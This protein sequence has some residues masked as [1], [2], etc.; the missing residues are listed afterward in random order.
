MSGLYDPRF[1]HDACGLA[2]VVRLDGNRT[3]EVVAAGIEALRNLDHRGA[4]GSDPETGD[5]AGILLQLP[6]TF[7]R[8][9][10]AS[11]GIELP[12]AG[13]YGAG[14]LFE[15]EGEEGSGCEGALERIV[16]EEGQSLLGWREVPVE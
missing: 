4:S 5:G 2:A 11:L 1:E 6:D 16:A 13:G 7:L 14:T 10:C 8:R 12:P 9:R 3:R 15:F